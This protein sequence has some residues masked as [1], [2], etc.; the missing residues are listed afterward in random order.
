M[1]DKNPLTLQ[2]IY[3]ALNLSKHFLPL[4]KCHPEHDLRDQVRDPEFSDPPCRQ[5]STPK[6]LETLVGVRGE[7]RS[8][9][10]TK[11]KSPI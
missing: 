9:G 6:V 5:H 4:G 7:V 11:V 3:A 1:N 10:E 8:Q 2:D